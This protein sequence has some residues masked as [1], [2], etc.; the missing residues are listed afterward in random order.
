LVF[1]AG[2]EMWGYVWSLNIC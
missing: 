2:V 1:V